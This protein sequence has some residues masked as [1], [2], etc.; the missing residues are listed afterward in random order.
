MKFLKNYQNSLKGRYCEHIFSVLDEKR[1]S[2][3]QKCI[4]CHRIFEVS[5]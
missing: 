3:I 1:N 4:K 2:V 5:Y